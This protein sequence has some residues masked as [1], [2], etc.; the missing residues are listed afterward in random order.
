MTSH[1]GKTSEDCDDCIAPTLI[2]RLSHVSHVTAQDNSVVVVSG[3]R[4]H[5]VMQKW[6]NL[7]TLMDG[8]KAI[9][10]FDIEDCS[11]I[12]WFCCNQKLFTFFMQKCSTTLNLII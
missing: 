12:G 9:W 1:A 4:G 2:P 11:V 7:R 8:R 3:D 10:N 6:A 5:H